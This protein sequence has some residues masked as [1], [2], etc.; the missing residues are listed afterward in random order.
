M[1][2]KICLKKKQS[3]IQMYGPSIHK[4]IKSV[5][6]PLIFCLHI[7]YYMI[8]LRFSVFLF[9]VSMLIELAFFALVAVVCGINLLIRYI[10][11]WNRVSRLPLSKKECE[12]YQIHTLEDYIIFL[13]LFLRY[14]NKWFSLPD[15][16]D[17]KKEIMKSVKDCASKNELQ[18][19][20]FAYPHIADGI[21]SMLFHDTCFMLSDIAY[22]GI[23]MW[24]PNVEIS[25][26]FGKA[27]FQKA[28]DEHWTWTEYVNRR[29]E[30]KKK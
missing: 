6:P 8:C 29:E 12:T 16:P 24:D 4:G 18:Q 11:R 30:Y 5:L 23:M 19:I 21:Y 22:G 7:V 25:S 27:N 10:K 3:W 13:N 14:K 20:K 1:N 2:E 17:F 15:I 28:L 26:N 9:V